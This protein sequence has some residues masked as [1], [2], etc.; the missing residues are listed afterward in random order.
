MSEPIKNEPVAADSNGA[1]G[2]KAP[3]IK[4]IRRPSIIKRLV[5]GIS[6]LTLI[7]LAGLGTII[8]F[9]ISKLNTIQ[10]EDKLNTTIEMT[11]GLIKDVFESIKNMKIFV[12]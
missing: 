1:K 7:L 8:Y 4:K 12:F 3:K 5:L 2:L 6:T 11:D 10:F 9:R